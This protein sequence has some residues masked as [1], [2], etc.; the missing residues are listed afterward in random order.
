MQACLLDLRCRS[1]YLIIAENL[2]LKPCFAQN[3]LMPPSWF[4]CQIFIYGSISIQRTRR[5]GCTLAPKP[6]LHSSHCHYLLINGV[7]SISV[8]Q[9]F[10]YFKAINIYPPIISTLCMLKLFIQYIC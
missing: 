3:P 9:Y 7:V 4:K 5:H 1:K 6:F 2:T 10:S 8:N